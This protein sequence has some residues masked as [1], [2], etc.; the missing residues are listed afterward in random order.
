MH[1]W[2]TALLLSLKYR[3]DVLWD[4]SYGRYRKIWHLC[5]GRALRRTQLHISCLPKG[6]HMGCQ[7]VL[8]QE[9]QGAH[10]YLHFGNT[11]SVG[12]CVCGLELH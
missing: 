12:I 5:T 11:A 7:S 10:A 9:G 6:W 2:V 1:D 4:F 8:E 3:R